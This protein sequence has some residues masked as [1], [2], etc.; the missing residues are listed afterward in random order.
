MKDLSFGLQLCSIAD[1]VERDLDSA[2]K[3]V[4]EMGYTCVEF[5]RNFFGYSVD[6]VKKTCE[7]YGLEPVSEHHKF[8]LLVEEPEEN[9][10]KFKKLGLKFVAIP[11]VA[12]DMWL[13]NRAELENNVDKVC[14][15]LEGSGIKLVYHNHDHEFLYE[16]DGKPAIEYLLEKHKLLSPEFD[17]CWVHY[18]GK[19]P[20]DYISKYANRQEIIHI[21]DLECTNLP[22]GKLFES[23]EKIKFSENPERRF[24]RDMEADGFVFKPV[25]Y[26]RQDVL[27]M[28]KCIENTNIKYVIIEQDKHPERNAME[29]A[30]LSID[31]IRSLGY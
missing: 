27:G 20:C 30:K 18:A 1:D 2:L 3:T 8:S 15:S 26:G 5:A 23:K 11:F 21:K 7:K 31:Y 13:S 22:Q 4:A 25:G 6:E 17:T 29:D 14:K 16:I 9:I 12:P 19:N 28:L 24:R 10:E